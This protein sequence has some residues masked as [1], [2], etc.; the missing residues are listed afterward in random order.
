MA[1]LETRRPVGRSVPAAREA[2]NLVR[3]LAIEIEMVRSERYLKGRT[4]GTWLIGL[5]R[6]DEREVSRIGCC[7]VY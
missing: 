6:M 1:R 7:L 3:P 4:K 2:D 5:W